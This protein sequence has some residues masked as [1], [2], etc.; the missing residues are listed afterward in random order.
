MRGDLGRW[1]IAR[2][3]NSL[4]T[5]SRPGPPVNGLLS[6]AAWGEKKHSIQNHGNGEEWSSYAA[7][8]LRCGQL[9]KAGSE[10]AG[11][12][13]SLA[14]TGFRSLQG[15]R[16]RFLRMQLLFSSVFLRIR[17]RGTH[18]PFTASPHRS[19]G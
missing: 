19:C 3:V 10:E 6:A 7:R 5:L 9:T 12:R 14:Q 17:R 1:E 13:R 15:D 16:K 4:L 11:E 8:A 18:A 2:H